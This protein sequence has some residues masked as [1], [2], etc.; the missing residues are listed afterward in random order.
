MFGIQYL[1]PVVFLCTYNIYH[2]SKPSS[3]ESIRCD[4]ISTVLALTATSK[5][6]NYSIPT[7]LWISVVVIVI[8]IFIV[9]TLILVIIY[10]SW[11]TK[12]GYF[13]MLFWKKALVLI[14]VV[15][16][17]SSGVYMCIH[18]Y[19]CSKRTLTIFVTTFK[20]GTDNLLPLEP[21]LKLLN[22]WERTQ[23]WEGG[24]FFKFV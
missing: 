10:T 12:A 21:H 3:L 18:W 1:I 8:I 5:T 4:F 24:R 20:L 7:Y 17:F 19:H 23:A 14:S 6:T 9:N 15:F 2:W 13:H 22:K 11:C 16:F